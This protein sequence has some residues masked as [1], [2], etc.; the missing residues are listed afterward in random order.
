MMKNYLL[1][2]VLLGFHIN[3][4]AQ[5]TLTQNDFPH[6]GDSTRLTVAQL[7]LFLNYQATGANHTWNFANL[8]AASQRLDSSMQVSATNF[9]YALFYANFGF[10]PNRA[11]VAYKG[12]GQAVNPLIPLTNPFSFYFLN[13]SKYEQVGMGAE[14]AN[15]PIPI[16]FNNHDVIYQLPL[17]F[18]DNDT[19]QSDWSFG[20]NGLA[21]IGYSQTRIN[22]VDGWGSLTTPNGTYD[23]LRVKTIRYQKDSISIDS[24]NLNLAL[25]RPVLTEYKWLANGKT[26]PVM[27]VNTQ[28]I[29]G[30]E[31][32]TEILFLD[33]YLKIETNALASSAI[34]AGSTINVPYT[35][36]G[37]FN[38]PG[39][40]T[41]GNK[42]KAQISDPFGSFNAP[43]EI[44]TVTSTSSGNISATI[45][46][47]ILPG[48]QYRI[49]VISTDLAREGSDNGTDL[50]IEY[51]ISA[52][53]YN[54]TA[55][56]FCQPGSVDLSTDSGSGYFYEWLLNGSTI[57]GAVSPTYTA[58]QS[59]S[60]SVNVSN[61]CG[62]VNTPSLV[63]TSDPSPV[64]SVLSNLNQTLCTGSALTLNTSVMYSTNLQWQMNGIDITAAN[65]DSLII[66]QSGIYTMIATNN[67]GTV[68]TAA[69]TISESLFPTAAILNTG[70]NTI[71]DGDMALLIGTVTDALNYHWELNG[72]MIAG[73]VDSFYLAGTSG[74]YSLVCTNSCGSISSNS[75]TLVVNP[76]PV[77]P[78]INQ[79]SDSLIASSAISWQWYLN[80]NLI[81][82][83]ISSTYLPLA[84]GTYTV[85]ITDANGCT[86][87]S[88]GFAY[89]NTGIN[90]HQEKETIRV[91][92]NPF[93]HEITIS[94]SE[95]FNSIQIIDITGRE[96]KSI[97]NGLNSGMI[98][99]NT[100]ELP[101]GYYLVR[102]N[103]IN[104]VV[105]IPL[106][107]N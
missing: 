81:A 16:K 92:P 63:V 91:Y 74:T 37:T 75:I 26:S 54:A 35:K 38:G 61:S 47:A 34:C 17:N 12:A 85:M 77:Q 29:F 13:S 9:V 84:N 90:S 48:N 52:G 2:F 71:C 66:T 87:I 6:A 44:G 69:I 1:L 40:F 55:L 60:Y 98:K 88:A 105:N 86:N 18:G 99:I 94:A 49:R 64:V 27:Q 59:G 7:N 70:T 57:Q 97:Y 43:V 41:T 96:V 104:N 93:F 3:M 79:V 14:I 20:L 103:K 45:P 106:I 24:L 36:F 28:T 23:V 39:F 80:G 46:A 58:I 73:A 21:Y 76:T 72:V 53:I 89:I 82:G 67:C 10:N 15:L 22:Q 78:V 65:S 8:K 107:K 83:A 5:I 95:K 30:L 33:D 32:I 50:T 56:T 25:S 62:I 11:S 100:M 102:I 42:F 4:K 51:P 19:S 68:T 101:T 31:I